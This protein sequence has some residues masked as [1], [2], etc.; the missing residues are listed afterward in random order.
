MGDCK[1]TIGTFVFHALRPYSVQPVN[2]MKGELMTGKAVVD[3]LAVG[4]QD[5][6]LIKWG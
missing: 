5:V 6:R 1:K 3:I 4:P 2:G